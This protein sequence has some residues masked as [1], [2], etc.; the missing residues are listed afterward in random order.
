[1]RALA[2]I[3][4]VWH[5]ANQGMGWHNGFLGVDVFFV[6]SGFLITTLL[7]Q[8]QA[9]QGHISLWNFYMRRSLRIFPAYFA[10]LAVLS[11]YFSRAPESS[12]A[13]AFFAELPYHATYVSNWITVKSMMGFTWSLATEEQFYLIWPP[14]LAWFGLRKCLPW[15]LG[16]V[17]LNQAVNFGAFDAALANVGLPYADFH[18]LQ[19]TFT[20]ILLGVLL[21]M[22]LQSPLIKGG[23]SRLFASAAAMPLLLVGLLGLA[24]WPGDIRGLPRLGFHLVTTLWLAGLVLQAP[25]TLTLKFLEWRPLAYV[26]TI[27]YGVYLF[28]MFTMDFARRGLS[29][30]DIEVPG[31]LFVATMAITVL[32]AAGSFHFM[33]KPLLKLK[34][35]FSDSPAR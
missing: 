7:L 33:E 27:S 18:I 6:L 4:V 2:V 11:V 25:Q 26:G 1:M 35:F 10:L 9:R 16:F 21:A 19:I 28:H 12:Q 30:L 5:H 3:A 34:R 29:K 15:L 20:P 31:A 14:L 22:A 13:Q 8:E 23:M 24:C 32:V 17:A